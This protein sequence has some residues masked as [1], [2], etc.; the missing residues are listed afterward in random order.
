MKFLSKFVRRF[1]EIVSNASVAK[2]DF[3]VPEPVK[4]AP[5]IKAANEALNELAPA[6]NDLPPVTHPVM[7]TSQAGIDLIHSFEGLRLKAYPD[8]GTGG[9]PWTIGWGSTTDEQGRPIEPG[10]VWTRERADARFRKHLVQFEQEVRDALGDAPVTQNQ[11]DAMVSLAYNIGCAAFRKSTLVR[12]HRAGD[13]EGAALEF[14]RW[15]RAG[16]KVMRGLIR[17]REA[18]ARMYRGQS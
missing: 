11:F 7:R 13:Y 8:P 15:N 17:R 10:T 16:G 5:T 3:P 18:E 6:L 14:V 12:K 4:T 9:K 2:R 1:K